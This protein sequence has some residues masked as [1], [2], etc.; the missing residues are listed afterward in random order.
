MPLKSIRTELESRELENY[1]TRDFSIAANAIGNSRH[2]F[3]VDQCT[4]CYSTLILDIALI[5][6]PFQVQL[7]HCVY[8]QGQ[9]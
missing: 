7:N 3:V 1:G 9:K 2:R 4:Y 5:Q 8:A 6:N